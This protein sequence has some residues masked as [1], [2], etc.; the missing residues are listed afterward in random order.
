[1]SDR[2]TGIVPYNERLRVTGV[3]ILPLSL[4]MDVLNKSLLRVHRCSKDPHTLVPSI[5]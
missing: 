5:N 4:R 2:H 3:D 1:M